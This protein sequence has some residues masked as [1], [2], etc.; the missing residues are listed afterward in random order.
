MIVG[1]ITNPGQPQHAA[2]WRNG[3]LTDLGLETGSPY[4]VAYAVSAD[5]STIVGARGA[6]SASPLTAWVWHADTG[7][8]DLSATLGVPAGVALSAAHGVSRDGRY[9]VGAA[10][11]AAGYL[12]AFLVDTRATP[13]C[14]P[15]FNADGFLDFFDYDQFVDCFETGICPPG[16]S[17]DFN[18]DGFA[19]FFDYDDFVTA[20]E[21]GC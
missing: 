9:I 16:A 19:D 4:S 14:R 15:D 7:I 17:A 3:V 21:A 6:S 1:D 20:F 2:L 8:Q 5:G 10:R 12:E 13:A 18:G 11:N